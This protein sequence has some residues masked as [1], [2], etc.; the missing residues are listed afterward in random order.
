MTVLKVGIV[1]CGEVV[2]IMHLPALRQLADKF[3]VSALCDVSP[4]VV[5][6]V[7]EEFGISARYADY[8]ELVADGDVDAVLIANPN[9][10]HAP[11]TLAAIAAGKHVLVEKPMCMTLAE[12]DAIIAAEAAARGLVVQVGYMR[13]YAQAFLK[14]CEVL[15]TLGPVRL[16]RVH[17]VIGLNSLVVAATSRVVRGRDVP[18]EAVEEG[19]RLAS[20]AMNAALGNA[21][22][23]LRMAYNI[24]LG[25]SSHDLSA[26]REL[27]G[28][29]KRV[30]HASQRVGGFYMTAAFDYG[31]FVCQFETGVDAI[32][33]FDA[34]I[35]VY[36]AERSLRVDYDT[37]YVRNMPVRLEVTEANGAGGVLTRTEHPAWGDSFTAEWLAFHDNVV[38]GKKPKTSPSDFR[39]DLEIFAEMVELMR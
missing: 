33:R 28:V 18:A 15:P 38:S 35:E 31:D 14:A 2:Q 26:M 10:Y 23:E 11:V 16:A 39:K 6:G 17:D 34:H 21:S 9:A 29:P 13:R 12:A 36:G 4:T 22:R 30:L 8:R 25:L 7:G 32:P 24:L 20:E 3:S 1:G 5:E 37:P 19:K 27:I